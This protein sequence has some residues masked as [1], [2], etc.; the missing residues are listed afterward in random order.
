MA[1]IT[2]TP[3]LSEIQSDAQKRAA[4]LRENRSPLSAEQAKPY[5]PPN[6]PTAPQASGVSEAEKKAIGSAVNVGGSTAQAIAAAIASKVGITNTATDGFA[7]KED[8][9]KAKNASDN[10]LAQFTSQMLTDPNAALISNLRGGGPKGSKNIF[11]NYMSEL[12]TSGIKDPRQKLQLMNEFKSDVNKRVEEVKGNFF[13]KQQTQLFLLKAA[14]DKL[15]FTNQSF[16][17]GLTNAADLKKAKME[18]EKHEKEL[19]YM[20][21]QINKMN[22]TISDYGDGKGPTALEKHR[23]KLLQMSNLAIN[24]G[25]DVLSWIAND[26]GLGVSAQ[27]EYRKVWEEFMALSAEERKILL[28][29]P[30]IT[31]TN[32]DTDTTTPEEPNT[33]KRAG[34]F[35]RES[36]LNTPNAVIGGQ[37]P[38]DFGSSLKSGVATA[39]DFLSGLFTPKK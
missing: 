16:L 15:A 18:E 30:D 14:Q 26:S 5:T 21:A 6:S 10:M 9:G 20:D 35:A 27:E 36:F 23:E 19:A 34:Q 32:T 28:D 25:I 37:S 11:Q 33:T 31:D 12:S 39:S 22:K 3:P 38:R 17:D 8:L 7:T 13:N 29:V 24:D 2:T 4:R 1:R